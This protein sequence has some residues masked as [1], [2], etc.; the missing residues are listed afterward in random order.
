[1]VGG[2]LRKLS[3]ILERSTVSDMAVS[4]GLPWPPP[5]PLHVRDIFNIAAVPALVLS[6][7]GATGSFQVGAVRY[8]YN[9]R[10]HP[11]IICS[12]SVGAV[13]GLKLAE[14]EGDGSDPN[15]GLQGLER[16]SWTEYRHRYV[17]VGFLG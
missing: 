13:N 4:V 7:G 15:R 8:L 5:P 12:T 6:G 17:C 3:Q 1:M 14:G 16:I 10:V 2:S 9:N 11:A